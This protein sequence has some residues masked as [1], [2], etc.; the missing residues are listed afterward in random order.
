MASITLKGN[1]I[2]TNG[3]LPKVGQKPPDFLLAANDLSE[4]SLGAY[5]GKK[6]ILSVF[7][8][9]DTPVCAL[10]VRRF[11]QEAAKLDGVVVLNISADL[12]FAQKRFCAAEGIENAPAL[13]CFRASFAKDY[14]LQIVDGPLRGLCSRAVLVLDRDNTVVY[15][16]QVPEIAQEPD[17]AK[18]LAAAKK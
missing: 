10:S 16:E 6:K 14:G 4:V 2:H 1:P 9:L 18:A 5:K 13:S 12:P 11:N 17:Y 3:E 7:P 8:S 15:V